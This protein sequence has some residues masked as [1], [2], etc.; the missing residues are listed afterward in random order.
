MRLLR[1]KLS[2]RIE[3]LSP[4]LAAQWPLA[5]TTFASIEEFKGIEN[6]VILVVDLEAVDAT[7]RH[8]ALLY[9]AMSR[10]RAALWVAARPHVWSRTGELHRDNAERVALDAAGAR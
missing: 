4:A 10:A 7:R 2:D 1:H 3:T 5:T 8:L 9:V 6:D